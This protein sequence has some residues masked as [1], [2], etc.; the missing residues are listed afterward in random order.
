MLA[1]FFARG[2]EERRTPLESEQDRPKPHPSDPSSER[3]G[4]SDPDGLDERQDP[5]RRTGGEEVADAVVDG[6]HLG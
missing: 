1:F 6:D 5:G 4:R 3:V 2:I